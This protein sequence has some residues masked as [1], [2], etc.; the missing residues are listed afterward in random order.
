MIVRI[1]QMTFREEAVDQFLQLFEARKELIRHFEGCS[2]LELWQEAGQPAVFFTYSHWESV[3]HLNRYRF[4]PLFKD[5]WA[6][7]KALFAAKPA[8]W[9]V[10]QRIVVS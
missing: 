5:T 8:A 3:A 9:S 1:V 7:T 10:E 6:Q 2:H 4:S